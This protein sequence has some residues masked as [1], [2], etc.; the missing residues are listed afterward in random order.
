MGVRVDEAGRHDQIGRVDGS[1]CAAAYLSDLGDFCA[2]DRNVAMKSRLSA[3]V[4]YR[5]VL[6][7]EVICHV[8]YTPYSTFLRAIILGYSGR[9]EFE[10]SPKSGAALQKCLKSCT[11]T[12]VC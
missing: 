11:G 9:A 5:S 7:H 12:L 2:L 1:L 4:D 6:D 8:V 10:T 3:P